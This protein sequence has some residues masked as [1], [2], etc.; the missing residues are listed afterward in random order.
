MTLDSGKAVGPPPDAAARSPWLKN[1][2]WAIGG[3]AGIL[4][5]LW[6]GGWLGTQA[7]GNRSVPRLTNAIQVTS[8][9]GVE[10]AP[11][12]SPDGRA[13][14]YTAAGDIWVISARGG[15]PVNRTED[16]AGGNRWPAWSPDGEQIAYWS[17]RE[18]GGYFVIPAL[19]GA[20]RKVMSVSA[21]RH[22]VP[23]WSPD[24]RTL[25]VVDR[26]EDDVVL[27][28]V[29]LASRESSSVVLPGVNIFRFDPSISPDGRTVTY[30][31]ATG[32][33]RLESN[34]TRLWLMNLE[35]GR[36]IPVTSGQT[37][38]W[39]P[40]WSRDGRTLYVISNRGGTMD[41]WQHSIGSDGVPEGD[42]LPVTLGIEMRDATFSPDGAKLAYS[43]GRTVG[44]LW[45]IPVLDERLATWSDAEQLTFD[46]ARA[47]VGGVSRDGRTLLFSSDR[48]GNLELYKMSLMGGETVQLTTSP[49]PDWAPRL[50]PDGDEVVFY[51]F[52]SGNRDLWILPLN[53]DPARQLTDGRATGSEFQFPAWSPDG[54]MVAAVR[55]SGG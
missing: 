3:A 36:A 43:R 53:G 39:T 51:S 4:L 10:A 6:I 33:A 30:V 22:V 26:E 47:G 44:N 15:E 34:V 24:G 42:P 41:L 35:S 17:D 55:S 5:L 19:G 12:W 23:A 8:A 2:A 45:R 27:K 18:G 40:S 25:S 16:P 7:E 46:R 13:L 54:A 9:I 37:Q 14:A 52:R 20:P 49:S 38:V 11:T 50:S 29:S 32:V 31:D 21:R 48:S 28:S 1:L